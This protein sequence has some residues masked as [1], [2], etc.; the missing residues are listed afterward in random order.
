MWCLPPVQKRH[1]RRRSGSRSGRRAP[2]ITWIPAPTAGTR[3]FG[4]TPPLTSLSNS[5]PGTLGKRLETHRSDTE[6]AMAAALLLVP[7][8]DFDAAGE[9][10]PVRHP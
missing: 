2:S 1:V 9:R 10:L 4:I 6:L 3:F 5:K 8:L 7:S